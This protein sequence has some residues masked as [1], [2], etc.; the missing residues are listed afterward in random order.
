MRCVVVSLLALSPVISAELEPSTIKSVTLRGTQ[1]SVTLAT[2]VGQPYNADVIDRDV[3]QLWATKRF[4]DI[5][6]DARREPDGTDVIFQ[7]TP[8]LRRAVTPI[9][10]APNQTRVN[11]VN[12]VGDPGIDP[13]Q[14][15]RA[16]RSLRIRH[17]F[18]G[19]PGRWNGWRLL[20]DY[21]REAVDADVARLQ[22]LYLSKGYFDATV[23]VD[24]T[25]INGHHASVTF[26]VRSGPR[27]ETRESMPQICSSLL[28]QRR[29]AER[30]G[31]LDF[32]ATLA[33]QFADTSSNRV[34]LTTTIDHGPPYHI[35]RIEFQ[36]NRHYSDSMLRRNLLIE[37]GQ[38]LDEYVLR[39]SA[40]RLNQTMLFDP[41]TA[42]N[43]AIRTN[44]STG[45]ADLTIRLNEH[46]RG[47]WNL[48]GPVGPA[49]FA[50]PLVASISSRL[51]P[52]GAGLFE[53]ST[54]TASISLIAFAQPLLPAL[55]L[56]P[57]G[58]LLPVLAFSRPFLPGEGWKSGFSLAPQLGWRVIGL[59]YATTQFEQRL[60]PVLSGN[61]GL[62]PEL[63]VT[64]EGPIRGGIMFCEP[65]AP[66]LMPLRIATSMSLRLMG[67]LAG[68]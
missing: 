55:A 27:Y 61:R 19:I 52:W 6:V 23:R 16:L 41:I 42:A 65:P 17:L 63:P 15:R 28:A 39:K 62:V 37:E 25:E 44:E 58:R 14:L 2:Q 26:F 67:A 1:L 9:Q 30:Q 50:G 56:S 57:T 3:R 7:V 48:S 24:D 11:Q 13:K 59:S 51:P 34:N 54:Y 20:P 8:A 38:L 12:F 32:S 4:D 66:R 60:L 33:V 29:D 53:L 46:K 68:F 43:I 35:G 49:S 5:R 31:I 21:S 22:S 36:G 45:V 40:A 18:P 64:V 47:A 10:P